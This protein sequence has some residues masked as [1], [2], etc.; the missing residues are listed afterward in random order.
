[1]W[2]SLQTVLLMVLLYY[3]NSTTISNNNKNGIIFSVIIKFAAFPNNVCCF[4]FHSS[5]E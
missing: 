5:E 2:P 3:Y 1:M 4:E